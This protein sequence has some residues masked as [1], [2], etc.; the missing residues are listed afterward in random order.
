[1]WHVARLAFLALSASLALRAEA[2]VAL[3]LDI[4]QLEPLAVQEMK[5]EFS[6]L[7]EPLGLRAEWR[8]L[9]ARDRMGE[10]GR[11]IVVRF[12]G[13]C[14]TTSE[15]SSVES[16]QAVASVQEIDGRILPFSDVHCDALVSLIRP[17]LKDRTTYQQRALLGR[18]LARILAHE[19]Y[20]VVGQTHDHASEGIAKARLNATELTTRTAQLSPPSSDAASSDGR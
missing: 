11:L 17:S 8:S 12:L 19:V 14:A 3:Y 6:S 1:M 18:A 10:T 4:N 2:G 5:T 7:T 9:T 16:G 15:A 20:H 13:A